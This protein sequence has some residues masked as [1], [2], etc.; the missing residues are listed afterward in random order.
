MSTDHVSEILPEPKPCAFCNGQYF[1]ISPSDSLKCAQCHPIPKQLYGRVAEFHLLEM[2]GQWVFYQ[3]G[4]PS[5]YKWDPFH[6]PDNQ[7]TLSPDAVC[8]CNSTTYVDTFIHDGESVRCDC[9]HCG[10][11]IGFSVWYGA[12]QELPKPKPRISYL[13][14]WKKSSHTD[15]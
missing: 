13:D 14:F 9:Q 11:T 7:S 6:D 1:W 2:K 5:S 15:S 8:I 10:R 4:G 12:L 3:S